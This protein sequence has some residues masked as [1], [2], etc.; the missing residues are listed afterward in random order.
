MNNLKKKISN[1]QK[2]LTPEQLEHMSLALGDEQTF[3]RHFLSSGEENIS[4]IIIYN[5]NKNEEK[6]EFKDYISPYLTSVNPH[7]NDEI[8]TPS[9]IV[10]KKKLIFSD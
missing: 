1:F 2:E 6:V 4:I 8:Y 7:L 9:I 3:K 10:K 5:E